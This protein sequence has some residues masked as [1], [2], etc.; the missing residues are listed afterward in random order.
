MEIRDFNGKREGLRIKYYKTIN[1][2]F[3]EVI[4]KGIKE[5]L[6]KGI[7][8]RGKSMF[9]KTIITDDEKKDLWEVENLA[10]TEERNEIIVQKGNIVVHVPGDVDF[11][12][13][14]IRELIINRFFIDDNP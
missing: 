2:Y 12:D 11:D 3:S 7:K 8:W 13:M 10:L 1:P 4:F 6:R 9:T 5:E 14:Q